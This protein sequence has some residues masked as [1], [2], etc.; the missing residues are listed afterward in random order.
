M[1]RA[2]QTALEPSPGF[3]AR[4]WARVRARESEGWPA[5]LGRFFEDLLP[6][7]QL[8]PVAAFL[9]AAFLIGSAGGFAAFLDFSNEPFLA[10]GQVTPMSGFEEYKGLPISSLSGTYLRA[11]EKGDRR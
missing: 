10:G 7:P 8:A 5:K 9:L 3:E 11:I 2:G 1:L 6:V 4:F